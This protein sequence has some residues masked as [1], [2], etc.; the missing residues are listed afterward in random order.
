M[1]WMRDSHT[2]ALSFDHRLRELVEGYF[3]FLIGFR[4][5]TNLGDLTW[6]DW[7]ASAASNLDQNATAN[8]TRATE[9]LVSDHTECL[10]L[11]ADSIL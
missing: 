7:L 1:P 2:R 8:L 11:G 10:Q 6:G 4:G 3:D 5:E 9:I